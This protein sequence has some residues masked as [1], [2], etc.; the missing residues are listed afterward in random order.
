M[1]PNRDR[2][3]DASGVAAY[4]SISRAM[5]DILVQRGVLPP[6]I[7][8]TPRLKRWDIHAI[9]AVLADHPGAVQ[10]SRSADDV[11]RGVAD[12]FA[13]EGHTARHKTAQ[14]RH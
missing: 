13:A 6:P 2:Y 3:R 9:D 4:L 1:R 7:V 10:P 14:R 5:V 11:V 8:L 12:G